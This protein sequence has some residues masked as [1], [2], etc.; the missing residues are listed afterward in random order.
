MSL[1]DVG[2]DD[3]LFHLRRQFKQTHQ[4]G[5]RRTINIHP[6][7]KFFLR[8]TILLQVTLERSRFFDCVQIFALYVFDNGQ[9]GHF[10][11]FHITNQDGYPVEARKLS[12]SKA[13][14]AGDDLILLAHLTHNDGLQ[15]TVSTDAIAQVGD[16]S[17]V[18]VLAWLI[19]IGGDSS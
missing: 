15:E 2:V 8:A 11:I 18:E 7:G 12:S 14:L 13:A 10:A 16:F 3:H 9:L 1:R 5:D 4:V 6:L 17:L 19:R